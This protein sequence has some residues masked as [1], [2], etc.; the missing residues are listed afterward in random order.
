MWKKFFFPFFTIVSLFL[1]FDEHNALLNEEKNEKAILLALLKKTFVDKKELKTH[2]DLKSEIQNIKNLQLYPN[3]YDKFEKF[4]QSFFKFYDIPAKI[5]EEEKRILHLSG[6]FNEFYV[7]T[8]LL[9]EENINNHFNAIK[10]KAHNLINF[11]F[12]SHIIFPQYDKAIDEK[13]HENEKKILHQNESL[14]YIGQLLKYLFDLKNNNLNN[15]NGDFIINLITNYGNFMNPYPAKVLPKRKDF[16]EYN[17]LH[18]EE[19]EK[20][21]NETYDEVDLNEY[22]EEEENKEVDEK[23]EAYFYN[24]HDDEDELNEEKTIEQNENTEKQYPGINQYE[25][26][27]NKKQIKQ[28]ESEHTHREYNGKKGSQENEQVDDSDN[29][30]LNEIDEQEIHDEVL[31]EVLS[32]LY[33][34]YLRF[35]LSNESRKIPIDKKNFLEDYDIEKYMNILK[36]KDIPSKKVPNKNSKRKKKIIAFFK[37]V[38]NILR[39]ILIP[40]RR[41]FLFFDLKENNNENQNGIISLKNSRNYPIMKQKKIK[42]I[43]IKNKKDIENEEDLK[44]IK[45]T[46]FAKIGQNGSNGFLNFFDFRENSL[47]KNL[48]DLFKIMDELKIF[49]IFETV[50]FVQ[51]F[52]E[53]ICASYCMDITDAVEVSNFDLFL[54]KKMNFTYTDESMTI[55]TNNSNEINLAQFAKIL[56]LLNINGETIALNC[57]CKHYSDRIISYCKQYKRILKAY[58]TKIEKLNYIKEFSPSFALKRLKVFQDKLTKIKN[59]ENKQTVNPIYYGEEGYRNSANY[60]NNQYFPPIDKLENKGYATDDFR[61]PDIDVINFYYNGTLININEMADVTKIINDEIKSKIFYINSYRIGDQFFTTYSNLGKDDHDMQMLGI[62]TPHKLSGLN[63]LYKKL[64]GFNYDNLKSM[65]TYNKDRK[66]DILSFHETQ[67]DNE[68]IP[69]EKPPNH[70]DFYNKKR[71]YT[72]MFD[73]K[74]PKVDENKLREYINDKYVLN[75]EE[76]EIKISNNNIDEEINNKNED[77]INLKNAPTLKNNVSDENNTSKRVINSK[78]LIFFFKNMHVWKVYTYCLN[79]DY[80]NRLLKNMNYD[81]DIIFEENYSNNKITYYFTSDTNVKHEMDME[82]FVFLLEKVSLLMYI[83][84]LCDIYKYEENNI[85]KRMDEFLE[86]KTSTHIFLEK[87]IASTGEIY[88]KKKIYANE[89]SGISS[90]NLFDTKND[91]TLN[92]LP[93]NNFI[94]DENDLYKIYLIYMEEVL[95]EKL[96][97]ETWA[98]PYGFMIYNRK[99]KDSETHLKI[100]QNGY[101][102]KYSRIPLERYVYYEYK[103]VSSALEGHHGQLNNNVSEYTENLKVYKLIIYS[104]NPSMANIIINTT[105]NVFNIAF[106]KCIMEVLLD[107]RGQQ[108]FF[109]YKGKYLPIN[110]FIVLDD[111]INYLFFNYIPNENHIHGQMPSLY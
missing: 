45:N 40:D 14:E 7:D 103:R 29:E 20:K 76:D 59:N 92:N 11:I 106:L 44:Q 52:K 85:N 18:I 47:K 30:H 83:E 42:N 69:L 88:E 36:N 50:I 84:D 39:F 13:P 48:Q 89:L 101:I 102:T 9:N 65:Y 55:K 71:L 107:I 75:M 15:S 56:A 22:E 110:T 63:N 27:E 8:D 99:R 2:D 34:P 43:K 93:Y 64:R 74:E 3:D 51:K 73:I 16:N 38:L 54:Y 111:E 23:E 41:D 60:H 67:D 90:S 86:N 82:Y 31:S 98:I 96:I 10:E 4:L 58:F 108:Q 25:K 21:V 94:L 70:E 28:K 1:F 97:N 105:V 95:Q 37:Y 53:N 5:Y 91:I 87:R 57:P 6:I 33:N 17:R 12:S 68:W 49:N 77:T 32:S 19:K 46:M 109:S 35:R 72:D 24:E 66:N 26:N 100:I 80:I 104:D 62:P 79:I 61:F 81:E 78:Y